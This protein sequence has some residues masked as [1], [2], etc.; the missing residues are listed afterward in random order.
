[1]RFEVIAGVLLRFQVLWEVMLCCLG[2]V[3]FADAGNLENRSPSDMASHYRIHESLRFQLTK[4]M[5]RPTAFWDSSKL[6]VMR[7]AIMMRE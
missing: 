1:M 3:P 2:L 7:L 4:I 5:E 6:S